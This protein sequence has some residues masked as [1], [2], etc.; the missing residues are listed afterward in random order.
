MK[1]SLEHL[2]GK[3]I[4][5]YGTIGVA[6]VEVFDRLATGD[7]IHIK[8]QTTDFDQRIASMEIDHLRV[9]SVAKGQRA[10]IKVSDHVRENDLVYRVEES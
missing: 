5:Y 8:G 2:A 10:G 7:I 4:K 6:S 9:S 1:N 3:I